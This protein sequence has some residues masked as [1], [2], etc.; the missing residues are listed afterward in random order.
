MVK[1]PYLRVAPGVMKDRV[2]RGIRRETERGELGSQVAVGAP[3]APSARNRA[4]RSGGIAA[5]FG[6]TPALRNLFYPRPHP[7]LGSRYS[8]SASPRMFKAVTITNNPSPGT[9]EYHH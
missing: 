1:E 2:L 9:V 4:H 3:L 6:I 8:R 5:G 7:T